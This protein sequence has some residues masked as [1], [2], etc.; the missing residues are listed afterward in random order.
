MLKRYLKLLKTV[1]LVHPYM[2]LN[3]LVSLELL[4]SRILISFL[5][6]VSI[7]IIYS[8]GSVVTH[9]RRCNDYS[10]ENLLLSVH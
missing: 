6:M 4:N 5:N 2:L 7:N 8:Q 9:C 3:Q 10:V 1:L